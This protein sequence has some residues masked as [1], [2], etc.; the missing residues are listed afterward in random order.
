MEK[1]FGIVSDNG[2]KDTKRIIEY[3]QER[4]GKNITISELL[5]K[6]KRKVIILN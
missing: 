4:F 2:Y 6:L 3:Y 1:Y 5:D